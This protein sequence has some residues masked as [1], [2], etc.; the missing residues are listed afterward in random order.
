VLDDLVCEA[1]WYG[2][3]TRRGWFDYDARG[4]T[5][6]PNPDLP[7]LV[8]QARKAAGITPRPIDDAE[9]L[10]RCLLALVNEGA[11]ILAEG[12][13]YRASDIDV[14]YLSGFGFPRWRG[15]PMH[16][17]D[18]RGLAQVLARIESFAALPHNGGWWQPSPLLV[19]LV[20]TGRSLADH[21][22]ASGKLP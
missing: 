7:R 19:E 4:R 6:R 15:G 2:Q 3:K 1:G 11:K 12:K 20:R 21:D 13:A 17:A 10:D 16:W 14:I 18:R 9:I 22:R 5:P 8:D